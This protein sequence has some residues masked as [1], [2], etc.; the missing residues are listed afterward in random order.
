MELNYKDLSKKNAC[1][2]LSIQY[3]GEGGYVSADKATIFI[4]TETSIRGRSRRYQARR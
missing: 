4:D 1:P 3:H 2:R